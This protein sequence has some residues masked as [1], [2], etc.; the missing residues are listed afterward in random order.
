MRSFGVSPLE[1]NELMVLF[2]PASSERDLLDVAVRARDGGVLAHRGVLAVTICARTDW[3]ES[4]RRGPLDERLLGGALSGALE[5][6][7]QDVPELRRAAALMPFSPGSASD[8]LGAVER[9]GR[10]GHSLRFV[11]WLRNCESRNW[12]RTRR[13]PCDVDAG[14]E[15]RAGRRRPSRRP[16]AA[17]PARPRAWPPG[18]SSRGR[19]VRD[20]VAGRVHHPL[21]GERPAQRRLHAVEGGDGHRS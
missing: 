10:A 12:S 16:A 19:G 17:S 2:R 3:I 20:V 11:F 5:R 13:K 14:A 4:V 9:L 7:D 18:A 15:V 6:S 1:K 8:E 21:L